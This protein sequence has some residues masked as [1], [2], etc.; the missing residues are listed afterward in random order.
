MLTIPLQ[1]K[2]QGEEM[3]ESYHSIS[4][5]VGTVHSTFCWVIAT[6]THASIPPPPSTK[7]KI[8]SNQNNDTVTPKIAQIRSNNLLGAAM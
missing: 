5:S 2:M 3:G 8:A 6:L 7:P 4:D 1:G